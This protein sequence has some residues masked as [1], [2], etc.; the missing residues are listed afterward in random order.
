MA[1]TNQRRFFRNLNLF[2]TNA[3]AVVALCCCT[4]H[5]YQRCNSRDHFWYQAVGGHAAKGDGLRTVAVVFLTF[6]SACRMPA[7]CH[8]LPESLTIRVVIYVLVRGAAP[9]PRRFPLCKA[10]AGD[11]VEGPTVS[12]RSTP[13]W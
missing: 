9:R 4:R 1:E 6:A 11:A 12:T 13:P 3:A 5:W 2:L 7:C 8:A 10:L